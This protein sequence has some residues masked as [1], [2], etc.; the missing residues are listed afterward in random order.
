MTPDRGRSPLSL[1]APSSFLDLFLRWAGTWSWSSAP[2]GATGRSP[3]SRH[4]RS[5]RG[6]RAAAET[7]PLNLIRFA[8][9]EGAR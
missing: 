7:H 6:G 2:Q 5:G 8:P 9:A 1:I 3:Y 4:I